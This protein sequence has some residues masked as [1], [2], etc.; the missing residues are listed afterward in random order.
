M[1]EINQI[2]AGMV[3]AIQSPQ[4]P[5]SS[6]ISSALGLDLSEAAITTTIE[7]HCLD[8]RECV[9]RE[10]TMEIG[11]VGRIG[12]HRKTPRFCFPQTRRSL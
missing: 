5:A 10:S 8:S 9:F 3:T 2:L 12:A 6:E 4:F 1:I 11:V 7:R